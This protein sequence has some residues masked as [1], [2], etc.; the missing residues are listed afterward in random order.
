M[1]EKLNPK[2]Y[3]AVKVDFKEDGIMFARELTWEDGT[4]FEIDTV[5]NIRQAAR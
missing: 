2:G 5:L 4:R 1:S 3:V